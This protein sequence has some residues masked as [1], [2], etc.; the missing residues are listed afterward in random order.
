M[1]FRIER[2]CLEPKALKVKLDLPDVEY[3]GVHVSS[4]SLWIKAL[5]METKLCKKYLGLAVKE[6]GSSVERVGRHAGVR[7]VPAE[8]CE[9]GG[10]ELRSKCGKRVGWMA[11]TQIQVRQ[12]MLEGRFQGLR[13]CDDDGKRRWRAAHD[14]PLP[15]MSQLKTSRKKGTSDKWQAMEAFWLE[16]RDVEA[17][18]RL[19]WEHVGSKTR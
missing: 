12:A 15:E 6:E 19:A 4:G 14:E 11:R 10:V 7:V 3:R 13:R 8:R 9:Q 17:N 16:M 5:R 1:S 2:R 18:C